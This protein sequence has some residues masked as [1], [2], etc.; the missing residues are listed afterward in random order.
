M[1][2][3]AYTLLFVCRR[4]DEFIEFE[5]CRKP[6]NIPLRVGT[7]SHL[8]SSF[9]TLQ[10]I[11]YFRRMAFRSVGGRWSQGSLLEASQPRARHSLR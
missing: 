6:F 8:M 1:M 2:Y 10:C 7:L 11:L 3:E 9:D 4:I 5:D